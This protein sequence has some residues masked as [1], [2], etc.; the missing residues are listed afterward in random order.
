[1]S[2]AHVADV[3]QSMPEGGEALRWFAEIAETM[4]KLVTVEGW[5]A[6]LL[7][8]DEDETPECIRLFAPSCNEEGVLCPITAFVLART[9]TFFKEGDYVEGARSIEIPDGVAMAVARAADSKSDAPLR[10]LLLE[11]TGLQEV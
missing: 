9:K 8:Y 7:H 2:D 6:R 10:K 11:A 1:M 3:A 5:E 4:K